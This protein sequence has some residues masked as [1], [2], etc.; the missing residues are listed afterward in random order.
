M[1]P[2]T[3]LSRRHDIDWLRVILFSLLIWFHFVIFQPDRQW[4]E[5]STLTGS[6]LDVLHQWRL[7]ALF[8]ISGMGTAFAFRRRTW[9][10][11]LR[12]RVTRLVPP[13]LLVTYVLQFGLFEP[14][15]T[16]QRL[17]SLF[18]GINAM[19]YGHLWFVFNLLIYSTLLLPLFLI[20]RQKP[21][22]MILNSVRRALNMPWGLGLL[23]LPVMMLWLNGVL[24]KPWL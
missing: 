10:Q 19:P 11:Y 21:N 6:V 4:L 16:T 13:L 1:N 15:Q 9:W 18:P 2:P 20:L 17:F 12:G 5:S 8:L 7:A 23:L 24:F 14:V 22:N 3:N